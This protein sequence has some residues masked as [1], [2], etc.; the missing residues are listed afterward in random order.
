MSVFGAPTPVTHYVGVAG[1]GADAVALP[2]CHPRAGAFGHDRRTP[3]KDG[4]PD[5][6]S[7][8]L[9]L[10][11]TVN[12]PGHWAFGGTAT[13]RFVP[14]I[15]VAEHDDSYVIQADLPGLSEADVDLSLEDR[16]LTL[17]GQ[18]SQ[19]R[20]ERRRRILVRVLDVLIALALLAMLALVLKMILQ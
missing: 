9:L 13:R 10:I 5:G 2:L 7:T 12:A 16:V 11:E 15:D 14:A 4:F 18:R 17:S 19:E 8:T 3:L 6:T 20:E 1:V